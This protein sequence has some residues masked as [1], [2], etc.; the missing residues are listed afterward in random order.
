MKKLIKD[1]LQSPSGKYSRKSFYGFVTFFYTLGLGIYVQV[2][3]S[4]TSV[5]DSMLIFLGAL[6]LGTVV[7]KKIENKS[8]PNVTEETVNEE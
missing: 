2:N 5:F 7:D 6:I 8:V 3:D 1:L 4:N